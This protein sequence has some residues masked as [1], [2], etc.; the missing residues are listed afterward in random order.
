MHCAYQRHCEAG[1]TNNNG[2]FKKWSKHINY[3]LVCV[4][5]SVNGSLGAVLLMALSLM[6]FLRKAVLM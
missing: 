2:A 5:V 3:L 1:R 4:C 6:P